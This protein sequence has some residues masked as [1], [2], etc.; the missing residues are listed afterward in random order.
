LPFMSDFHM[1]WHLMSGLKGF[2]ENPVTLEK[3]VELVKKRLQERDNNFL[4]TM[5]SAIYANPGSPYLPLLKAA[6][7]Q[8]ADLETM[9]RRAGLEN[10]LN[11]LRD[12][13]VYIT[14]EEFKGLKPLI[15]NNL[16]MTIN[17]RDFDNP[18]ISGAIEDTS[19]A[20]RSAGTRI[21]YDFRSMVD[22]WA[23]HHQLTLA[24]NGALDLPSGIWTSSSPGNMPIGVFT[25]QKIGRPLQKRFSNLDPR[26]LKAPFKTSLA[27]F[28]ILQTGRLY[29]ARWPEYEYVSPDNTYRVAE[30]IA[31]N[32][33]GRGACW[34]MTYPSMAVR[35]CKSAM[36]KGISLA[37]MKFFLVGEPITAIKAREIEAAGA[38][39]F[40][41]Y[42]FMEGG[43]IGGSCAMPSQIGDLHIFKDSLA[44][45]QRSREVPHASISVN[46]SLLTS[47]LPSAYKI[48]LNVEIGDYC[49]MGSRN[50]G[51]KL[52]EWGLTEHIHSVRGFDKLTGEG[53]TLIGTDLVNIIEQVLPSRF[54]GVSTDYQ[55]VEEEDEKAQTRL[56]ILADPAVGQIDEND[57][58]GTV[59]RELGKSKVSWE[60]SATVLLQSQTIR[61]KR[62]KPY[63]T[64]RGKLLPLHIHRRDEPLP[65]N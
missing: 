60:G 65:G 23:L 17:S 11:K 57:L 53:L 48:L 37:G 14:Y 5:K 42:G 18:F 2:L 3:G 45:T 52:G 19:G 33:N 58:I 16:A 6:G 27:M 41:C 38:A 61:L 59:L 26:Q 30:W 44:L 36:E 25:M 10:T 47:L 9:T 32:L 31:S 63:I 50:C 22:Q 24:A 8:Y 15:R 29:G 55:I 49:I 43:V 64:S 62:I 1:L 54:G 51:C 13:G 21:L 34:L 20:S 12:E 39:Y 35:I 7:C 40:A 28:Y 4:S 46:A 56:T